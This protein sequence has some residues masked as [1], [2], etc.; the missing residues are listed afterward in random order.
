[1]QITYEPQLPPLVFPPQDLLAHLLD[2]WFTKE[3]PF[4][5]LFHR[6]T[7]ER[8]V[9]SG[10]HCHDRHF[11]ETLLA[12]CAISS[13]KSDDP[14]LFVYGSHLSAGSMWIQQVNPVPF[15]SFTEAPSLAQV[16][17]LILYILFMHNTSIPYPSVALTGLG[18]RLLQ[19]VG[20][21][22]RKNSPPTVSRE[23]WKRAFWILNCF[24]LSISVNIGSPRTMSSDDYDV[25]FPIECDDDTWEQPD[26]LAFKQPPG[27]LCQLTYSIQMLKLM[28][29]IERVQQALVIV[30]FVRLNLALI[31]SEAPKRGQQ[32]VLEIDKALNSWLEAIPAH[33]RWDP[34]CQDTIL[35]HQSAMLYIVYFFLRMEIRR[36][37]LANSPTS[38]EICVN[39]AHSCVLIMEAYV[40]RGCLSIGPHMLSTISTTGIVL[41][42]GIWRAKRFGM[43]SDIELEMVDVVKCMLHLEHFEK[44]LV[45]LC[46]YPHGF[47]NY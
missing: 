16:Q 33:L 45:S 32:F 27:R 3:H 12:V 34:Q 24:D 9:R 28:S 38:L 41:L 30:F 1:W 8:S 18:I 13:R 39:A 5:P 10:L 2:L 44:R 4:F 21:H 31:N 40:K 37:A 15:R 23:L 29:I 20:A 42:I 25:E 47:V 26:G 17:K 19:D 22:P 36:S 35:F 43:E 6:P 46:E 7:F 11:G 14:R